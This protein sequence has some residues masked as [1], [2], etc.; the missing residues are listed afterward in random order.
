V[1]YPGLNLKNMSLSIRY[2]I[3]FIMVMFKD[4]FTDKDFYYY[5]TRCKQANKLTPEQFEKI[6]QECKDMSPDEF[7]EKLKAHQD[8]L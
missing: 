8:E 3:V 6:I 2:H 1:K 7:K 5:R 4:G